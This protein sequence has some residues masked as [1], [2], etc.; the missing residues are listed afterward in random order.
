MVT[1]EGALT[2]AFALYAQSNTEPDGT[3]PRPG[4]EA[5]ADVCRRLDRR[6]FG[7]RIAKRTFDIAFSVAVIVVGLVPCALLS[8]AIAA[9]TKGSP[10]YTQERAG[11]LGRP[12]RIFKF[13]SM[14]ADADDVE[15]YLAPAQL[16]QWERERKVD[17]DPRITRLG[18]VLRRTSL[19]ELPQF[20]NVLAG[21]LSVIGPR[22]I[23][24]DEL[25]EYGSD[26][27]LLLSVPQGIT[28]AW[29]A[30]PRNEAT[31]ENGER[32]A[33]ELG[34]ARHA[35]VG[36]DARVFCATFGAMFGSRRSGR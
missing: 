10:I 4:T 5:F 18:R 33:I 15:K 28:G 27:P 22:A 7:Y 25:R 26:A 19:D 31:F 34:Y 30:G 9:D 12:F 29:Q 23:T 3:L 2:G 11:R 36:E 24:Y 35:S 8:V 17:G 20:L 16:A 6:P 14:V 32:Q 13:R 21:Q 1:P